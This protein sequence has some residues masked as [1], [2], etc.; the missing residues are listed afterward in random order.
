MADTTSYLQ[1]ILETQ[2]QLQEATRSNSVNIARMHGELTASMGSI[3]ALLHVLNH[4]IENNVFS[5]SVSRHYESQLRSPPGHTRTGTARN[6]SFML[7]TFTLN[8]SQ[9]KS[10]SHI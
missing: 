1:T 5:P 8:I 10:V 2:K 7:P 9:K 3:K 4:R 6:L